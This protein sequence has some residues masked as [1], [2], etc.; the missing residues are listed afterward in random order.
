MK[1]Y[2]LISFFVAISS[3][4]A[5][6]S[7][8]ECAHFNEHS[9]EFWFPEGASNLPEFPD[10]VEE[11]KVQ[12]KFTEQFPDYSCTASLPPVNRVNHLMKPLNG[13]ELVQSSSSCLSARP[14]YVGEDLNAK[15]DETTGA[16]AS[17]RRHDWDEMRK[18]MNQVRVAKLKASDTHAGLGDNFMRCTECENSELIKESQAAACSTAK[19]ESECEFRTDPA[20]GNNLPAR[21]KG[22]CYKTQ[23]KF[24]MRCIEDGTCEAFCKAI[25]GEPT[26]WNGIIKCGDNCSEQLCC[27]PYKFRRFSAMDEEHHVPS[28]IVDQDDSGARKYALSDTHDEESSQDDSGARIHLISRSESDMMEPGPNEDFYDRH[29]RFSSMDN[30]AKLLEEPPTIVH[31]TALNHEICEHLFPEVDHWLFWKTRC[32]ANKCP[33]EKK[34]EIRKTKNADGTDTGKVEF[35]DPKRDNY[36]T[37]N[38]EV[39]QNQNWAEGSLDKPGHQGGKQCKFP[40]HAEKIPLILGFGGPINTHCGADDHTNV[41]EQ[42]KAQFEKWKKGAGPGHERELD[43]AGKCCMKEGKYFHRLWLGKGGQS[44]QALDGTDGWVP[45]EGDGVKR[46]DKTIGWTFCMNLRWL[47]C[48]AAGFMKKQMLAEIEGDTTPRKPGQGGAIWITTIPEDIKITDAE[49]DHQTA[50]VTVHEYCLLDKVCKNSHKLWEMK[51]PG[52]FHCDFEQRNEL[53]DEPREYFDSVHLETREFYEGRIRKKKAELEVANTN[54]FSSGSSQP[55]KQD[56]AN[57][58]M[59]N[60]HEDTEQA[61][62]NT[63]LRVSYGEDPETNTGLFSPG[64][65]LLQGVVICTILAMLYKHE[66]SKGKDMDE[67]SQ[68]LEPIID[69]KP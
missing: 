14:I 67:Y 23:D 42:Y 5:A 59:V 54:V 64:A 18:C 20:W 29:R 47:M 39:C 4:S 61:T 1:I 9:A 46:H 26:R 43:D 11:Y 3:V 60:F 2:V 24:R 69:Q 57:P 40:E 45:D 44:Q 21:V 66:C 8:R 15:S 35:E 27:R 38:P 58:E 17:A 33:Q 51:E 19:P 30:G 28:R 65:L 13:S 48:G 37:I 31:K 55:L 22:K 68:L 62:E 7:S 6:D 50:G 63:E 56:G 34:D 52:Y 16:S 10:I 12:A 32:G 53:M 25:D 36:Y 49:D 41:P